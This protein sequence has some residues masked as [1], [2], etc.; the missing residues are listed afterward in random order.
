MLKLLNQNILSG[1]NQLKS[2]Q[3]K[4]PE[5][6]IPKGLFLSVRR[7]KWLG[8]S[9]FDNNIFC[10]A[11]VAFIL[12]RVNGQMQLKEQDLLF[13][14]VQK[15]TVHYPDY[16]NAGFGSYNFWS[17]RSNAW[18][19]GGILL[20]RFRHFALPDDTDTTSMVLLTRDSTFEEVLMFHDM[21]SDYSNG[22]KLTCKTSLAKYNRMPVYSTW[23][24]KKM[25]VEIDVCVLSN[26]MY[27]FFKYQVPL[28]KH[29]IS[30]IELIEDVIKNQFYFQDVFR[31]APEYPDSLIVLFHLSRL[32]GEFPHYFSEK[33]RNILLNG[34]L[35]NYQQQLL[36]NRLL[37][38]L[39]GM[40][41]NRFPD[42]MHIWDA[43]GNPGEK[44]WFTAGFLSVYSN[45][46]WMK[47]APVSLFHYRF[48]CP[49]IFTALMIEHQ[50][51]QRTRI[52]AGL[53]K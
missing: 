51:L 19:P 46:L 14:M 22:A 52:L 17:T 40:Y 44:W 13:E 24:G 38:E 47:L 30:T 34:V 6:F 39:S 41:L 9:R 7:N 35:Q 11:S 42:P 20:H 37:S 4:T 43:H 5:G 33:S 18:F 36:N 31:I 8:L 10:S 53:F 49:S 28:N 32:I 48:Y 27:L 23:I 15:S 25:P 45:W 16:R 26:L 12:S 29:D 21:L 50:V 2:D 1:L 3:E